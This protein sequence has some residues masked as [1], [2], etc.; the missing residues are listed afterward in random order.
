MHVKEKKGV[1]FF[2]KTSNLTP[3]DNPSVPRQQMMTYSRRNYGKLGHLLSY[4]KELPGGYSFAVLPAV[5]YLSAFVLW[6]AIL[7][8]LVTRL[9][10]VDATVFTPYV[11]VLGIALNVVS[12][13]T[14]RRNRNRVLAWL[15]FARSDLRARSEPKTN[16]PMM[17]FSRYL[18]YV[19]I[20]VSLGIVWWYPVVQLE[21]AS[22]VTKDLIFKFASILVIQIFILDRMWI[23]RKTRIPA[24]LGFVSFVMFAVFVTQTIQGKFQLWVF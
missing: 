8:P 22:F 1:R 24:V 18:S 3:D 6:V 5:I 20:A 23:F 4:R 7:K 9:S 10:G 21:S 19:W 15:G 11:H 14:G 2:G 17:R 13:L 12:F 16:D